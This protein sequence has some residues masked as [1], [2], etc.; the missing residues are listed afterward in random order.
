MRLFIPLPCF[1]VSLFSGSWQFALLFITGYWNC[2]SFIQLCVIFQWTWVLDCDS[3]RVLSAST[4]FAGVF[5]AV[6]IVSDVILVSI[7]VWKLVAMDE[8]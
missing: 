2:I 8:H 3:N 7:F 5:A 1:V 4:V 6:G